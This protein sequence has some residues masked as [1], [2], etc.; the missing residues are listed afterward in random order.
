MTTHIRY[1]GPFNEVY[2]PAGDFFAS[3]QE[4]VEVSDELAESLLEQAIWTPAKVT[5]PAKAETREAK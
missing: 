2:V 3:Y 4:D 1:I 5:K